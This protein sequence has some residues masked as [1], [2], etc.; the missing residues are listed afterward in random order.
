MQIGAKTSLLKERWD[1]I[2]ELTKIMD[3][4]EVY[5]T[6][7]RIPLSKLLSLDTRWVVHGP[8]LLHGVNLAKEDPNESNIEIFKK[9]IILANELGA[10]YVVTHAGY[11]SLRDDMDLVRRTIIDNI[12]SL[13]RFAKDYKVK[14]LAENSAYNLMLNKS[15]VD[16]KTKLPLFGLFSSPK[17]I[18]YILR[19]IKCDFLL[20]FAHA[21][22]TS[23]NK[24]QDYNEFIKS[25]MEFKPAMF[26]ICDGILNK[27][28]DDHLS[29]GKGNYDLPFFLSLIKDQDVTL[30]ISP[31]TLENFL[32]SKNCIQKILKLNSKK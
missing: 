20:D 7:D 8:H 15:R 31:V 18:E 14:L 30:E 27:E 3:F 29:L 19:K 4:I 2:K 5:Y 25:L 24:N 23:L 11:F 6:E 9:S 26:H 21:Y 16:P 17:E 12:N 22:I 32:D 1:L 13:K 10:E 28:I